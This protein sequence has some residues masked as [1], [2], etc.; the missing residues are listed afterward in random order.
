MK[1]IRCTKTV[2]NKLMLLKNIIFRNF[3]LKCGNKTGK[4][5]RYNNVITNIERHIHNNISE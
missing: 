4:I 2:N 1:N 5:L 3:S